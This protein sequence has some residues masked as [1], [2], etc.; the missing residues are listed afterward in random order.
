MRKLAVIGTGGINSWTVENLNKLFDL[1][2]KKELV[3]VK[4]FDN[5][6]VEEKNILRG[7]QNFLVD[8]LL[9]QKAEV[10]GK[11]YSF[12][13]ENT[14]ITEENVD[15]LLVGFDDVIMGVDNHKT[16][17]LIY[18]YCL[19][20][21]IYLLD[22]RAQGSIMSYVIVDGS[23]SFEYYVE[24]YFSNAE[25]MERKGSCQLQVDVENDH[26]E[27]A[28]KIIAHLGVYAIYLK[29]LRGEKPS[30]DEWKFVY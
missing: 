24:K 8:D 18:E 19:A 28:N 11:R 6:E 1:F 9:Q 16:R 23:K 22:L 15:N 14:L 5:D 12:D 25:V 4:L 2:D 3:Y 10:L 20:N 29:R 13:Y 27:N 30:T 7:N 17:K 26:I 21:K